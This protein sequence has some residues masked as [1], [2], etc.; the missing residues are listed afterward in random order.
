[1]NGISLLKKYYQVAL[2]TELPKKKVKKLKL[3]MEM[4]GITFDAIYISKT[5]LVSYGLIYQDF[6]ISELDI[7]SKVLVFKL[8]GDT[9][10]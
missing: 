9:A 10:I 6:G 8:L 5:P 7:Q 3:L 1:M 2:I 4:N